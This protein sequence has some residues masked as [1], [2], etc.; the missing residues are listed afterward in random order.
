MKWGMGILLSLLCSLAQAAP[1]VWQKGFVEVAPGRKLYVEQR[2]A[3]PGKHT[4]FLLNGLTWTTRDWSKLVDAMDK[5]E[6]G[7]GFVLYDM[8][9]MG[10]TLLEYAPVREKIA[11]SDQINDLK[12]L[13][14]QLQVTGP[15]A[16]AGLSYGGAV[17]LSYIAQHPNDFDLSI[18]IAPFIERLTDQDQMIG[19]WID[20]H[21]M[22]NPWDP[23]T[24]EE[25]YDYYLRIL[26][27]STYPA[28]EPVL[29]E[30][31]YKLEATFRMVQD[32]KDFKAIDL[33]GQLPAGKL[34]LMGAMKDDFVKPERLALFWDAIKAKAVSF[35]KLQYTKHKIPS[36]RPETAAS[37]LIQILKGNPAIANGAVFDGDPITGQARNGSIVIPLKKAGICDTFLR[38]VRG[39]F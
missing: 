8:R 17:L 5:I 1:A 21:R 37:W 3:E 33:A 30:N 22:Y 19:K 35:L 9:G 18:A 14:A 4:L 7:Y 10:R 34:H 20:Q 12:L 2:K 6:P 23:R 24:D 31:P 32:A 25:L 28:L 27:Y 36:E 39:P 16:M 29:L 38:T 13:R 26:I 11:L 15:T